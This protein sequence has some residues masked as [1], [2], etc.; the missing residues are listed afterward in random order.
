LTFD[1]ILTRVTF[2]LGDIQLW[3]E[4]VYSRISASF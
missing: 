2:R 4:V 1:V 3:L